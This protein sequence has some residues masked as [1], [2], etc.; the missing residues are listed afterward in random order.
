AGDPVEGTPDPTER[1]RRRQDH[2]VPRAKPLRDV[3]EKEV[4]LY[5]HVRDLPAHIT[6]CPHASEAYRGEVQE[7]L[8]AM[9]EDHPGLRHSIMAGYEELAAL[10]AEKYRSS[11]EH[12]TELSPCAECG[13]STAR[14][15]CRKCS[16][17]SSIEAA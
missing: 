17:L 2:H 14:D 7:M 4:A 15:V 8:L 5:A 9:E 12:E 16:L 3:P 13:S 10:A 6:E 11:G 1:P